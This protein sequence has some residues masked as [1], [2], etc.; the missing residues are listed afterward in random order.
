MKRFLR[1]Y[2][3]LHMH[4]YRLCFVPTVKPT[5]NARII[6]YYI[7]LECSILLSEHSYVFHL[8]SQRL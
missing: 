4:I 3:E 8:S 7:Y 1:K 6:N 2:K 5:L